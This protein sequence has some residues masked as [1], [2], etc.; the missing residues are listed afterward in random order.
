MQ[1]QGQNPLGSRPIAVMSPCSK[2]ERSFDVCSTKVRLHTQ[3]ESGDPASDVDLRQERCDC[4]ARAQD[5]RQNRGDESDAT[6]SGD[7]EHSDHDGD[8]ELWRIFKARRAESSG[9]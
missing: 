7:E 4:I 3:I 9:K 2:I 5:D 1:N 8:Q 6:V